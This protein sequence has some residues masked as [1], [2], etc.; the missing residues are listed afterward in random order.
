ME[1]LSETVQLNTDMITRLGF[2]VMNEPI[3]LRCIRN[4]EPLELKVYYFESRNMDAVI[5]YTEAYTIAT[6]ILRHSAAFRFRK[7]DNHELMHKYCLHALFFDEQIEQAFEEQ[8][9]FS[10]PA[11]LDQQ[12][13]A[14]FL[15]SV[16]LYWNSRHFEETYK[17]LGG[18]ESQ[19]QLITH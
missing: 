10:P 4:G 16:R 13:A 6:G 9:K 11:H 7:S 17:T 15:N 12:K 8:N 1:K 19:K 18:I 2:R 3:V 5:Y 14:S